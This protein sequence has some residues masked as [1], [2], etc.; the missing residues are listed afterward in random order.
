MHGVLRD[1]QA[2]FELANKAT[3]QRASS[4]PEDRGNNIADGVQ[5][6]GRHGD[7]RIVAAMHGCGAK[8]IPGVRAT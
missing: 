3:K 5:C 8:H 7:G 1:T 6:V 2:A 4:L